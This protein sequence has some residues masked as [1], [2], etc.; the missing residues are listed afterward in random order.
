MSIK[1][2]FLILL[3]GYVLLLGLERKGKIKAERYFCLFIFKTNKGKKFLSRIAS[4]KKFWLLVGNIGI[5]VGILGMFAIFFFLYFSLYSQYFLKKAIGGVQPV[6]PGVTIPFWYGIIGLASVIIVHEI[7]HGILALREEVPIKSLGVA[8]LTIIPIGAFVEPDEET[9]K[10]RSSIAKLRVYSAGSFANLT[11]ALITLGILIGF[12]GFFFSSGVEIVD[13][14][15]NSP[16]H[17]ILEKGMIISSINDEKIRNIEDFKKVVMK[18]KPN[19]KVKIGTNKGVF[20]VKTKKNPENPSRGFLGIFVTAPLK[21]GIN[22]F[23]FFTLSWI[24]FLNQGIG[25]INLAPIHFGVA[26]TDGYYLLKEILSKLTLN[27]VAEKISML[28]STL[29]FVAILLMMIAPKILRF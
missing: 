12:S 6:I 15:K 25:L 5:I 10:K 8:L 11:L 3:V 9:L 14:A 2:F 24:S 13:I 26:A 4:F 17:G 29:T 7:S 27:E 23:L 16:S 22:S 18:I 20:Y 28:I 19:E 1:N 21:K